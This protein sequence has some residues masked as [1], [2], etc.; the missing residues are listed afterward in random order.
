M[1]SSRAIAIVGLGGRFPGA[2]SAE[3]LWELVASGRS[4][5]RD[6]P[7]ARW[8]VERERV[9]DAAGGPDRARSA[10][11]CLLDPFD[12][13]HPSLLVRLAL[14]VARQTF[15]SASAKIDRSRTSAII[16]N[17]ALP[18]DGAAAFAE[19]V[20][21]GELAGRGPAD[22]HEAFPVTWPIQLLAERFGLGGGWYTLDAACASSLYALHLASIE[23][24]AGRVDAV[25]AGGISLPQSIYTQVGFTQLQAL[26]PSGR[27]SP[28]TARADGLVVG[29]GGGM[30]LLKRLD[31]AERDGD[32]V[33][34]V[35]RGVGVSNDVGGSLLS[36]D[37]EGQRRAMRAAYEMAGWSPHEVQLVE[38]HG[39]GTPRGDLVELESLKAVFGTH[40]AVVGSVK[41]NVGHLLTA[42]GMAGLCKVI[43]AIRHRQ[44]PPN[45]NTSEVLSAVAPHRVLDQPEPWSSPGPRRAALSGFGFGGINAHVLIEE[46]QR[47]P[48]TSPVVSSNEAIAIVGAGFHV[49]SIESVEALRDLVFTGESALR[50]RPSTRWRVPSVEHLEGAWI[51]ALELPIGRFKLAPLEIPSVLAQQLLMLQVAADAVDDAGGL[52]AGPQ[53]RTG[54]VMGIGLDLETTTFHLRWVLE[55]RAREALQRMGVDVLEAELTDWVAKAERIIGPALD[56]PRVLGALGGI[57]TSRVARELSLGGPS[58]GVQAGNAS[59]LRALEVAARLLQRGE[60]DR[61]IVGAVEL[62]G[63]LRRVLAT[64][65]S[66][67]GGHPADGAVAFVVRRLADAQR[68]G[69]KILA[70]VREFSGQLV[71]SGGLDDRL[72]TPGAATG[73]VELAVRAL[74][75]HHRVRLGEPGRAG[76]WPREGRPRRREVTSGSVGVRLEEAPAPTSL[77]ASRRSAGLFLVN[78]EEAA[79]LERLV[80][81]TP[82]A[83]IDSLAAEWFHRRPTRRAAERALVA[84]SKEDLLHRLRAAPASGRLDGELAF[85]FPGSG[86]HYDGMGESLPLAMPQA[87]ERLG[88]E[89]KDFSQ[90]LFR[91]GASAPSGLADLIVRQV[92]HGLMVHDAL[93]AL[94]ISGQAYLGYSLGESVGLFASRIWRDRDAMF[95]RTLGSQLFRSQLTSDGSVMRAAWGPDAEWTVALVMR[96]EAEI[97]S[98]LTGT[99]ALLIVNAPGECVIGGRKEDVRAIVGKLGGAAVFLEGIPFVHLPQLGPVAEDYR[100]LHLLPTAPRPGV[101]I[102]SAAWGRAYE[103]TTENCA[104]SILANATGGFDF[105]AAVEQAWR[106]GVRVFVEPGPQGSCT[107]MIGRILAGKP[108]LAV[109]ACQRGQDAF[110]ALLNATARV[111]ESGRPVDL[112]VLYSAMPRLREKLDRKTVRVVL[113]GEPLELPPLPGSREPAPRPVRSSAVESTPL[114]YVPAS[115]PAS[116]VSLEG[117][118]SDSTQLAYVPTGL[119]GGT[120]VEAR[121][122][123]ARLASGT[124]SV[125]T[126]RGGVSVE[127]RSGVIGLSSAAEATARAHETFLRASQAAFAL[128]LE[129]LQQL[130]GAPPEPFV[131]EIEPVAAPFLDRAQ[132][133]EFAV[134]KISNV[135]GAAFA[136]IDAHPTRVRLPDEPLML[137]DRIVEVEGVPGSLSTGRVVTEHDVLPDAWYLDGGRAPVCI[138]VEAGQADLFLSAYLGIDEQTKGQRVYRLLDAKIIFH[139][140]LPR[141]GEVIRYDIRIDRFV[142]QGD[143]WLF[144]FRFDGTIDGQPFITMFDGCAGF[145]SAEQLDQGKGIVPETVRGERRPSS[146][147]LFA[148]HGKHRLNEMQVDALR[149]GNLTDA[150]GLQFPIEVLA[151]A[152]RLPDGRMRLVDRILELDTRGGAASLGVVLGEHDVT[153]NAWYLT[154]HFSDDPVMPG[155]LMY[156][157][158]LHTLRVLLLRMGWVDDAAELELHYAPVVGQVSQLKCRGQVLPS[159]KKVQY[160]VELEQVGLEPEPFVIATASMFADGRHVVEMK[161]M[162]VRVR[163]L[164]LERL[165]A[166]WTPKPTAAF[167]YEQISEYCEGAP[168]KC[169]GPAYSRFDGPDRRLARLPRD[170]YRFL[171]RVIHCEPAPLVMEPGGW[172]TC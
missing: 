8:A 53:L 4:M 56:A 70:V 169:F 151:P 35:L 104:A 172:I 27:C 115:A 114:A 10:K 124:M 5:A 163:G 111:A 74:E 152:L 28:F 9:V 130:H 7:A 109:S 134:G 59:G 6:V 141:A 22:A 160:R 119:P 34:A 68:D 136:S 50:A 49:G 168:S 113:G 76:A 94:G 88:L 139:R 55:R 127:S 166:L 16:A 147:R 78:R 146:A 161:G 100:A 64:A 153:P 63:D 106:D 57:V 41:S 90:H 52:G 45:A 82:S 103:P 92:T 2:P 40:G 123:S 25:L 129:L 47:G 33:M 65:A 66:G 128:Q 164:T 30:V 77:R 118:G 26:S 46:Y 51:A 67:D 39:T 99:A 32:R 21:L 167:T 142:R 42:A 48:V 120:R 44:L 79:E 73:L 31:D 13:D 116:S 83:S 86:S 140:E 157:C 24:E 133:L 144:F 62:G 54:A 108:H 149:R 91:P 121:T 58:F 171:D 101:R 97:R 15:E 38:C 158:C 131:P 60:V 84:G 162:S 105:T 69:A 102:Y 159:T 156:E 75:L 165:E 110:H 20:L 145:F 107:R 71:G 98:V 143:T 89:V 18:T 117:G 148:P 96:S 93:E 155:T 80:E 11:A 37:S 150:F 87:I 14:D 81:V 61:M 132:C 12:G 135:L 138:S 19:S 85:V 29:E 112:S 170:P 17:I 95:E 137:V 126:A 3:A 23:L 125:P 72:G 43:G 36:P 154:C 122:T 1:S